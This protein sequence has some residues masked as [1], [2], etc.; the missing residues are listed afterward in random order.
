MSIFQ[1]IRMLKLSGNQQQFSKLF[2]PFLS[3][4]SMNSGLE[5]SVRQNPI[6]LDLTQKGDTLLQ[7][8]SIST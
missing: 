2:F 5:T 4:E 7:T 8:F 6:D 3:P 1:T